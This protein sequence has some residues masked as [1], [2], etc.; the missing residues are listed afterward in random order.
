MFLRLLLALTV[1]TPALFG[2]D[3]LPPEFEAALKTFRAEGAKGWSFTQTTTARTQSMVEHYDP[4]KP[5]FARWTLLKVSD[6]APTEKEL[7]E[8]KEKHTRR[9][10]NDTAPDVTKQLDLTSAERVSDDSERVSYRFRLKSG[11]KDDTSSQYMNTIFTLHKPTATI[12]RVELGN[13]EP[14]S[15]MLAVK[16]QEA[17]TIITYS[18]PD[19]E[20]PTLLEKITVR[21]R[22]RAMLVKSLDED[23]TVAYSDYTYA[24]KKT[25]S[26]APP[27]TEPVKSTGE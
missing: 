6:R 20:R 22:G 2:A 21:V 19:A 27:E 18:L 15:P 24:A 13:T 23:M 3:P 1:F 10:S 8:Y 16:V 7:K 11:G 14:F 9:S 25:R 12:E 4:S 17:R 26:A 5:E